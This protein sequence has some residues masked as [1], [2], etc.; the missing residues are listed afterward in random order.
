M[1]ALVWTAVIWSFLGARLAMAQEKTEAGTAGEEQVAPQTEPSATEATPAD[2]VIVA[3]PV[4]EPTAQKAEEPAPSDAQ[5][6]K[7]VEPA[8][9]SAPE[10]ARA[11]MIEPDKTPVAK[12]APQG[13]FQ[14]SWQ[15]ASPDE[16]ALFLEAFGESSKLIQERWDKATS[17]ERRKILRAHPLLGARPMKH[18]WISTTP[19]ERA[20]FLETSAKTAQKVREAWEKATPEQRKML[21]LE[22]PYYARKAFHHAWMQATPQEK[23]AFLAAHPTLHG[24]LKARWTSSNAWQKQ[25]YVKNYPGIASVASAKP[26]AETSTEERA[27]F[28]EANPGIEERVREAW[29]RAQP[30]LRATLVRKWQGWPLRAYQARLDNAGKTLVSVKSRP[31]ATKGP[32]KSAHK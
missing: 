27:L 17:D 32:A 7:A 14:A 31:A 22:H 30:E 6:P 10:P 23:I 16:K 24:E 29:Q 8:P 26:W 3:E 19:E 15:D 11:E 21:A 1:R 25:W 4:A 5:A 12:A 28:L 20:A 18:R 2:E 13:P 9:P